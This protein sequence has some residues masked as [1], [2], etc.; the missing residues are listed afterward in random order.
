MHGSKTA[1]FTLTFLSKMKGRQPCRASKFG[2][3]RGFHKR[4]KP[5]CAAVPFWCL[6]ALC[7]AAANQSHEHHNRRFGFL[8]F[9][10]LFFVIAVIFVA[11]DGGL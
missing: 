4:T 1:L 9:A 8:L 2:E 10:V 7:I 3:L 6:F 11:R 5:M